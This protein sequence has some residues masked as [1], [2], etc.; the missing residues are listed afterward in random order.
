MRKASFCASFIVKSPQSYP[1][2]K[3]F[4]ILINF[5]EAAKLME[6]EVKHDGEL[7]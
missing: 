2:D 7:I 6:A 3:D 4:E 1:L 5:Q